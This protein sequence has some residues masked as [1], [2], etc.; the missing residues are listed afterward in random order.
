MG[1]SQARTQIKQEQFNALAHGKAWLME[2]HFPGCRSADVFLLG[3]RFG[4][5]DINE[6]VYYASPAYFY[7]AGSDSAIARDLLRLRDLPIMLATDAW[8]HFPPKT[9]PYA[10]LGIAIPLFQYRSALQHAIFGSQDIELPSPSSKTPLTPPVNDHASSRGLTTLGPEVP[11]Q[12]N[13]FRH[14]LEHAAAKG[15]HVIVIDGQVNPAAEAVFAPDIRPDYE[16]FLKDC[17]R[18]YPNMTLVWQNELL[19]EPTEA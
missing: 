6:Y 3:E 13:A 15:Q 7:M 10:A 4:S 14:F 18:S 12:K 16:L 2:F 19:V 9:R 5:N 11:Y 17:A 8:H 1:S